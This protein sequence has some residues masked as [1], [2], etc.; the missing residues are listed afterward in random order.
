MP[1]VPRSRRAAPSVVSTVFF[2][3]GNEFVSYPLLK[4]FESAGCASCHT[5][6]L[7]TDMKK[8]DLGVRRRPQIFTLN[9]ANYL[10][11]QGVAE[12]SGRFNTVYANTLADMDRW[13]TA[14]GPRVMFCT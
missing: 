7:Y 1:F 11:R 12:F 14:H 6:G 3:S 4:L 8:H 10:V 13:F 9:L 5:P 2:V